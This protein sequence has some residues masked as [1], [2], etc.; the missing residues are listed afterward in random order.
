ML[1]G[2]IGL[3]GQVA[4]SQTEHAN[5]G[6]DAS[7]VE[8]VQKATSP[9]RKLKVYLSISNERIKAIASSTRK[10][11]AEELAKAVGGFRA[12]LNQAED[13]L[14]Q[15]SPSTPSYRK[16]AETLLKAARKHSENL[17]EILKN[18]QEDLRK[19]IQSALE[20]SE[21]IVN[22]LAVQLEKN[23]QK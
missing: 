16:L 13:L 22:V 23:G 1:T 14:S 10:E 19:Y 6:L 11:N 2:W 21:R 8:A 15:Q 17:L 4:R 12:A 5:E 9:E 7:E 18:A 20:V 3:I